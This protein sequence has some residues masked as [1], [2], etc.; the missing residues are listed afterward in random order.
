MKRRS[1]LQ[2][3]AG[4]A[5][6]VMVPLQLTVFG[7]ECAEP[8][9]QHFNAPQFIGKEPITWKVY[10]EIVVYPQFINVDSLRKLELYR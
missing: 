9:V 2:A 4:A 6:A 8:G 1:F 10:E 5:A 3:L 7:N